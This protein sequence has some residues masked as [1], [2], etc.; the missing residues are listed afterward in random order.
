MAA[1]ECDVCFQ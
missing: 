1:G